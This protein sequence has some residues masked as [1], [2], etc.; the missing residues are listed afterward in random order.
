MPCEKHALSRLGQSQGKWKRGYRSKD[1]QESV[2]VQ[3][4][5]S[6]I[7]IAFFKLKQMTDPFF[8]YFIGKL[9][10]ELKTL[11]FYVQTLGEKRKKSFKAPSSEAEKSL[12]PF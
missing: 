10:T 8:L 5:Y 9:F 2:V 1:T 12:I 7:S 4:I 6:K 11:T 3:K